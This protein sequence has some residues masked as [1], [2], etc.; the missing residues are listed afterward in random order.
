MKN[1]PASAPIRE[2]KNR[3]IL[4]IDDTTESQKAQELLRSV[5]VSADVT[6]GPVGPLDKKPLVIYQGG[7]YNGLQE[8]K[9]LVDLWQFWNEQP[10]Q[11]NRAVFRTG[12]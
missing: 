3:V 5:G 11:E 9:Q 10:S 4:Y 6:D 8:I 1:K 7:F 12:D 2:L